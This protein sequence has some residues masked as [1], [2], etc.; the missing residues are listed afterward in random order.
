MCTVLWARSSYKA[1][2]FGVVLLIGVVM[3]PFMPERW[4]ERMHT[5]QTYETESSA[6]SRIYAWKTAWNIAV[7]R[8]Q[9]GGFEYPTKE[10]MAKYSPGPYVSVA[11]SIYFQALGEHGFLGLGMFLLFWILVW[12]ECAR[13]RARAR[14]RPEFAWAF[15][16]MSMTQAS[17][18]GYAVGGAFLN[19]AFWD[20]HYYLYAAI[21]VTG[22]V[23]EHA[24]KDAAVSPAVAS[25]GLPVGLAVA[26]MQPITNRSVS[27]AG[28]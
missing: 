22:Y 25:A 16:L 23:L 27:S 14:D 12:R 7:D 18:V 11:H 19:L 3:I 6:V 13:I 5:I 17:L 26:P 4:V 20:M 8:F 2:I 10:V 24:E 15:S 28:S 9:G 21:F 1:I